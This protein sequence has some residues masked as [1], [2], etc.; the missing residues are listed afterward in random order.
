MSDIWI[1]VLSLPI[2]IITSTFLGFEVPFYYGIGLVGLAF[3]RLGTAEKIKKAGIVICAVCT[4]LVFVTFLYYIN[5]GI[6]FPER[7]FEFEA[8]VFYLQVL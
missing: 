3:W 2:L 6:L 1:I 4:V 7:P 8:T 5:V